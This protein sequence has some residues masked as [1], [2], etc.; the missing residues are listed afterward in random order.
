MGTNF[1]IAIPETN[2]LIHIG[3]S[4]AGWCFALHVIPERGINNLDDWL[5]LFK[6]GRIRNEYNEVVSSQKM[7][8]IITSRAF[9][10]DTDWDNRVWNSYPGQE[11]SEE[12]FHRINNSE[13]GPNNLARSKIDNVRCI[14]H[15]EG[16][17]DYIVG[18]FS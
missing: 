16:T 10:G 3:K 6:K 17:W 8:E 4:S 15:G 9:Y 7:T 13:R 11:E 2:E 14:G 18:Y 5:E 12:E 1:Y